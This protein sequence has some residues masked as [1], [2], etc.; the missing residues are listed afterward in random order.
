MEPS[1]DK[2]DINQMIKDLPKYQQTGL[3]SL[4]AVDKWDSLLSRFVAEYGTIPSPE[5]EWLLAN[6]KTIDERISG[7]LTTPVLP[8][9]VLRLSQAAKQTRK[10]KSYAW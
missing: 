10:V 2:Q 7:D 4:D 6:F 8:D 5:P 3:I 9:A 1:L